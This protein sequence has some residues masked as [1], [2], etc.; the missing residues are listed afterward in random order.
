MLTPLTLTP[1]PQTPRWLAA[2]LFT[3]AGFALLTALI[4]PYTWISVLDGAAGG[5]CVG[6]AL[7]IIITRGRDRSY[8]ALVASHN[9][10]FDLTQK[11]FE[12]YEQR[13]D[14]LETDITSLTPR[15][16]AKRLH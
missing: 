16:P 2:L 8:N 10:I 11:M 14:G 15:D 1:I 4:P 5:F 7:N 3:A 6:S 13:V 9:A 12:D